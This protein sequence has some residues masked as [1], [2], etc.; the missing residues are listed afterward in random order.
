M[1]SLENVYQPDSSKTN[2]SSIATVIELGGIRVL[3]LADAWAE[4]IVPELRALETAGHSMIFDGIKISHHGSLRNTSPELLELV[5]APNYFISS[6]GQ[7]HG[8]PDIEVLAAIVDRSSSFTRTLYFNY[9]TPASQAIKNHRS[10]AESQ[11]M[12]FE[13]ATDWIQ[14]EDVKNND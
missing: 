4:D 9:S 1:K 12:V 5:D 2:G 11:F 7:K 6:N 10:K 14:I 3:M 8:H 13:N